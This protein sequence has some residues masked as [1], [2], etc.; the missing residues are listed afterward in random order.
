MSSS[1]FLQSISEHMLV[2]RYSRRT[3]KAY[4]YWIKLYILHHDKRHPAELTAA[5]IESFLTHLAVER[6]VAAATQSL[7]LNALVYLYRH[8]LSRPVENIGAFRRSTRQRKLP[9]VLTQEEVGRLLAQLSGTRRLIVS[10]LYGSGL[11]R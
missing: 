8:I 1:P 6:N 7:A 5:D 11:R 4:L 2:R 3:I 9:V 10:L